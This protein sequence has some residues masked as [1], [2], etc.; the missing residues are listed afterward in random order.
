M[1]IA[2]EQ[3]PDGVDASTAP[4]PRRKR[5]RLVSIVA[6]ATVVV[7]GVTVA[8]VGISSAASSEDGAEGGDGFCAEFTDTI[9]L[10]EGNPVTQM[11]MQVGSVTKIESRGTKVKVTFS[12]DS[13]RA[14]PAD[15]QAVTRSKSLLAD[16]GLELVGNYRGGPRLEPGNCIALGNSFTPKSISEVAGSASDFLKGLSNNGALDLQRALDGS[17]RAFDGT[18]E[19]ANS[20]FVNAARAARDP[21]GFTADIGSAISDMA[22]L[23]D[24]AVKHWSNIMSLA[25]QGPD[26]VGLGT[27]LFYDVAKFCRG[28][29]WTIALM[30]DI[31][32]NYGPELNQI[33]LDVGTPVVGLIA[34][35]APS[36]SKNL[37]EVTPAIGDTLRKQ[38][39]ATG[40]LSI[41]YKAPSVK[42]SAEQCRALGGACT[43]GSGTTTTVDPLELVLKAGMR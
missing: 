20:M 18:G 30:Y 19:K 42:V 34:E 22:P 9:G 39:S 2:N 10:Y 40:A 3:V 31:W 21:D 25:D 15:V 23:T 43:R 8:G 5:R 35:N 41:P 4:P 38:T 26:V 36:W 33:V 11:G 13:G 1:T 7:V 14:Y 16:R 6:A 28:I 17:D 29:G 27:T 12:L 37:S 32:K 24:A